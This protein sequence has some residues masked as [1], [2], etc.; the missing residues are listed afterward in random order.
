MVPSAP[1]AVKSSPRPMRPIR[2]VYR[3]DAGAVPDVIAAYAWL[4]P[5]G[6]RAL[7]R[8]SPEGGIPNDRV[9]RASLQRPSTRGAND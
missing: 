4:V 3:A 8:P 1:S 2:L 9:L 6:G 5:L 7:Q